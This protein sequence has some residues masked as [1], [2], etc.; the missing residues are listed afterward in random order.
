MLLLQSIV[1]NYPLMPSLVFVAI[2]RASGGNVNDFVL[3]VKLAMRG[4]VF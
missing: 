3:R 1:T 2:V 4:H